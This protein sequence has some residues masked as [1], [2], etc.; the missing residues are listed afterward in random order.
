MGETQ[1]SRGFARRRGGPQS[2]GRS[3]VPEPVLMG[4]AAGA[5]LL[6]LSLV[7]TSARVQGRTQ[8][9]GSVH[10]GQVVQAY[11]GYVLHLELI[12]GTPINFA[13]LR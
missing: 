11:A 6:L 5:A 1:E 9:K 4:G 7:L 10:A 3:K 13:F 12:W 2:A 8:S